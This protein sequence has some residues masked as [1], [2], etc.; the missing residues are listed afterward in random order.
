MEAV[1]KENGFKDESFAHTFNT[2]SQ[3]DKGLTD[4]E[5][6]TDEGE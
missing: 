6:A 3:V 4:V 1:K 2:R 5:E